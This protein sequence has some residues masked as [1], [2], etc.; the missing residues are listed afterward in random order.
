IEGWT[1]RGYEYG[2]EAARRP[3]RGRELGLPRGAGAYQ[4]AEFGLETVAVGPDRH[5]APGTEAL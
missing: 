4:P 3:A 5:Y 2:L 1:A